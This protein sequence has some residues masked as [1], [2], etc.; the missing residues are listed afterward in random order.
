MIGHLVDIEEDRATD[1][2]GNVPRTGV[3]RW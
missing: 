3:G 1:V 2:L